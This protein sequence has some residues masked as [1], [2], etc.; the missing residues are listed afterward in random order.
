M[1]KIILSSI[2]M[3]AVSLVLAGNEVGEAKK[4]TIQTQSQVVSMDEN[5]ERQIHVAL[6]KAKF[7]KTQD[8]VQDTN[9]ENWMHFTLTAYTNG[10]ESTG[11]NPGDKG[12]GITASGK[13][14]KEGRTIAADPKV[15]PLGTRVYID[16]IGERIVEDTGSAIKKN[17]IDVYIED[18]QEALEFGVKRNVKV[19]ILEI[20][21]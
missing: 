13:R 7:N 16:G 15:L 12:Y 1:R 3:L 9:E 11:K 6:A 17:K 5:T 21:D 18:L 19:K 20:G 8:E 4:T 14:T 10:P 2:I